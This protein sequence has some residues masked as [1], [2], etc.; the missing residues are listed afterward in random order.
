M[1]AEHRTQ[2]VVRVANARHPVAHGLVDGVFECSA[3]GIH[4][5]HLGAQQLHALHIQV[6]PPCVL[7]AH[8]DG[9][10]QLVS[11]RGGR[12]RDAVL[13]GAGFR[14]HARLAH[15]ARQQ[16]L[17]DGIVDLVRAGVQQ[18]LAFEEHAAAGCL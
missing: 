18:V 15:A 3:A 12:G 11:R 1:R 8:V 6:L 7:A 4:L 2:H 10:R 17:A 9:A 5:G 14:D 16:T 13:P